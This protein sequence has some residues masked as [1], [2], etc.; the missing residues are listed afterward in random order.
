ME[1]ADKAERHKTTYTVFELIEIE[2]E[3]GR[4]WRELGAVTTDRGK[5]DAIKKRVGDRAGTFVAQANFQP[6]TRTIEQRPIE[7]WE[8]AS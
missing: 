7:R 5:R 3:A 6:M 8:D 4:V 1:R 2:D